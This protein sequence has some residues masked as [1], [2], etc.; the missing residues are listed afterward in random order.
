MPRQDLRTLRVEHTHL[1]SGTPLQNNTS[2]LWS[3][4]SFLD[5]ALFPSLAAFE[6]EFGT[7]TD[8]AQERARVVV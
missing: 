2:E 6:S 1:L 4:L 5:A 3:L 7:L 8:A